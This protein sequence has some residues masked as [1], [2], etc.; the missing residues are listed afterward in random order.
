MNILRAT[1]LLMILSVA[2]AALAADMPAARPF[3][4]VQGGFVASADDVLPYAPDRVILQFTEAAYG[5]SNL[6]AAKSRLDEVPGLKTGLADVDA[7][8]TSV[9]AAR[10]VKAFDGPAAKSDRDR[11]G[12][13]RWFRLD[14]QSGSDVIAAAERLSA[15]ADVAHADPDWRVFPAVVPNDLQYPANWGHDNTAQLPGWSGGGHFGAGVGTV[16]FDSNADIAWDYGYGDSG[17]VIAI[18]DSGVDLTHEDIVVVTGYDYGD[19]DADPSDDAPGAGH[20]TACAGIAAGTTNNSVGVSGTAGGCSIM[21]LK[22]ADNTG[23]MYLSYVTS[24]IYYASNNGAHVIS[25]SIGSDISSY[26]STDTAIQYAVDEGL[27]LFAATGNDNESTIEYP[28][29][30]ANVIG[31]GAASPCGDRKRSSSNPA[32]VSPGVS[33]DP[34]DVTCDGERWWGSNYGVNTQDAAGAVDIIA[35]TI[36]PTTDITGSPGYTNYGYSQYFNGTSCATP[37]AAGVAALII[38]AQPTLPAATVRQTIMDNAI[39]IVNVESGAGWDRYSGYGMID[40][41]TAV[42]AI[43]GPLAPEADFV[44]DVTDGCIPLT[45]EFTDLSFGDV[46]SWYWE[47]GDGETSTDQHPTHVYMDAGLYSVTLT[48]TGPAGSDDYTRVDYIDVLQVP[49]PDFTASVTSGPAPLTVDFTDLSQYDPIYFSWN[50]GDGG[51]SVQQHPSHTFTADGT[52]TVTLLSINSCGADSE[53]KVDYITVGA[54]SPPVA[55]F[56]QDLT[57]ICTGGDVTFTDQ[58]TGDVTGW[59]WDFGDTGTSTDQNP[60][61]TYTDV[62]VYDVTLIVTGPAGA[63]TLSVTAAVTVADPPSAAF[64]TTTTYGT[65]PHNVTFTDLSAGAPTAW[66]W[67]FGDG[68][69]S[70]EQNPTYEYT[71]EGT[72]TVS[73]TV[74]NACDEDTA[75]EVD[76]IYIDD[77]VDVAPRLFA[78]E[79]NV[80]NPFNPTTTIAFSLERDG[81][82]RLEIFDAAGR[83][84]GALVDRDLQ[85]GRHTVT[86]RPERQPSGVYFARLTSG[87]KLAIQRMVLVR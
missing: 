32:Y 11:L 16:G 51:T 81:H 67:D 56:D 9:G 79:P 64:S 46:T 86:W 60:V 13:D 55:A 20:G 44:A 53:V 24:C 28:A 23:G 31:V 42:A 12:T 4:P 82:A 78:L 45:V 68:G 72:Y 71:V 77:S 49:I 38:S 75:T 3:A 69:S 37:Y 50:F 33:T 36:L 30:N 63:D 18:I 61:H 58:S 73:L 87:G 83:S 54:A 22:A 48:A 80:P 74:S 66:D 27:I 6:G 35:A 1:V 19:N 2:G 29:V 26:T 14:L 40:A 41:G 43:S 62:G 52:Y 39:D 8:L 84:L 34:N 65:P 85:Q 70:T 57:E 17:V 7:M 25:M 10:L 15:L 59:D 5:R 47:F 76:L 21:P